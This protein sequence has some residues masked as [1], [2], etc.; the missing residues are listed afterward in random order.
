MNNKIL[1]LS[2]DASLTGTPILL[3]N[4]IRWLKNN[5]NYQFIL[6]L[7][8]GGALLEEF[9]KLVDV[10]VLASDYGKPKSRFLGSLQQLFSI[11]QSHPLE[12]LIKKLFVKH[13]F[14]LVYSNSARN[15][16]FLLQVKKYYSGKIL[17]QV[18]EGL[19]TL[20]LWN[21]NGLVQYNLDIST[22]IIAVSQVVKKTLINNFQANQPISVIP[23]GI[24]VEKFKI[25]S[26][27][28][29]N[30]V[31]PKNS[32]V[33]VIMACGWMG[34]HKGTDY[35]IQLAN[36]TSLLRNDIRFVWLGG[37]ETEESYQQMSFDIKQL[38]LES[39]VTLISE[40]SA[41]A[42]YMKEADVILLL[43]REES[44]SM[45]TI[46]AG[47]LKK[48]VL[49]WDKVGGPCEI[50]NF[51]T[52][53]MVPYGNLK[54]MQ[55]KMLHLLDDELLARDMGDFLFE[56]VIDNYTLQQTASNILSKIQH[57][58]Q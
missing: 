12:L 15:G 42:N 19:K 21:V 48:P 4:N 24:D 26:S 10:H 1:I 43:S 23:G 30:L 11:T 20:N 25:A 57:L 5:S 33:K 9:S 36:L 7:R 8:E 49:F 37:H 6:L 17:T 47:I 40:K 58:I 41:P 18:H 55:N 34:W 29:T 39:S 16:D 54:A 53:F 3:L 32:Q 2:T 44:F 35:F 31:K 13:K 51:D 52:R 56:R 45:V 46:E 22:E 14:C 38:N 50:V 28:N 27:P